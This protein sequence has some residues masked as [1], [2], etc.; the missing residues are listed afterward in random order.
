MIRLTRQ[1]DY[2]VV[3]M[4]HFARHAGFET[5]TTRDVAAET[6]LPLPMA[7][8]ILK[9]LAK[10][11]LLESHRGVNGGYCLSRKPSEISAADIITAI[12]G[13]IGMTECSGEEAD[14]CNIEGLCAVRGNWQLVNRVVQQALERIT[15]AHMASPMPCDFEVVEAHPHGEPLPSLSVA[16]REETPPRR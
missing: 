12:E 2:G 6:H 3:V 15:L 10:G 4:T 9:A 16:S 1:A 7:S 8:K 5:M 11:G 14:G 13:P